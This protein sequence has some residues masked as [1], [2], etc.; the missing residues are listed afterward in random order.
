METLNLCRRDRRPSADTHLEAAPFGTQEPPPFSWGA[1][2]R[3]G[4]A[5]PSA[6]R[7]NT[8]ALASD[9]SSLPFGRFALGK[10]PFK[11]S[12]AM[13]NPAAIRPLRVE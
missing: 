7:D 1:S 9:G 4:E 2:L 11:V 12:S 5:S 8:G 3:A 6:R 13:P 10:N